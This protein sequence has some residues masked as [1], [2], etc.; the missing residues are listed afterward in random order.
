METRAQ[1]TVRDHP[2]RNEAGNPLQGPRLEARALLDRIHQEIAED[3]RFRMIDLLAALGS[4]GGFSCILAALDVA[5]AGQC[6]DGADLVIVE[7]RDGSRYYAGNLT[8]AFLLESH[9]S[10]LAL[11]YGAARSQGAVL[12]QET[13][14]DTFRH[15]AATIGDPQ[16]G[17]PRLADDDQPGALPISYVR[18]LWPVAWQILNMNHVPVRRRP[19]AIGMAIEL[20][21][22][23]DEQ[24]IDPLLAAR[25]VTECAV[26][27]AKIDPSKI[28]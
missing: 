24:T 12:S 22:A 25:I 5:E 16:F 21:F 27:M 7:T 8:N 3:G 28:A 11:T 19:L 4:I 26:P 14:L 15:V 13:V 20:A 1:S 2:R 17:R 23:I 10:L 18:R 9:D 6:R